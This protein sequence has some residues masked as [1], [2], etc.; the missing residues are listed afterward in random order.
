LEFEHIS[1]VTF[2]VRNMA[3]SVD[4]YQH[5]GLE[6]SYGGAG[7]VFTTFRIGKEPFLNLITTRASVARW[8]R[9]IVRVQGVDALYE[10]LKQKGLNPEAPE[11]EN[12]AA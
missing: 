9:V 7:A 8:G 11:M 4:F 5:I 2:A 1:A 12:G 6:V 3:R 10:K